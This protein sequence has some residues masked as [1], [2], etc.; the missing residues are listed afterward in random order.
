M[1]NKQ[2]RYLL[3]SGL[4]LYTLILILSIHIVLLIDL[5][6]SGRIS[7]TARFLLING[8]LLLAILNAVIYRV[9]PG[10]RLAIL[11]TLTLF[12][13]LVVV[14]WLTY[15]FYGVSPSIPL[16]ELIFYSAIFSFGFTL[17]IHLVTLLR[18]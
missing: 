15:L 13:Y 5:A 18:R 8:L 3:F 11:L 10:R 9:N 12:I 6:F 7:Y 1:P 16:N 2:Y 14:P 17:V 4:A